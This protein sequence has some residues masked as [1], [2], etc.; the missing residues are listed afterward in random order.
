[1]TIPTGNTLTVNED[2]DLESDDHGTASLINNGTLTA[3]TITAQRYM[4]ANKWHIISP[5]AA[6]QT[7]AAFL[8]ANNNIPTSS[9]NRGMMDYFTDEN[10]W[11]SYYPNTGATGTMDAG[12]GYSAR[13]TSADGVVTFS[14]TLTSGTKEVTLSKVGP[15]DWNC[16]GN[17]YP[18][19]IGMN[20]IAGTTENFVTKNFG[21]LDASYACVYVWD[22]D[23]SYSGQSCYKIISNSEFTLPG[24]TNLSQNYVAPGQGFFVKARNP[25]T[26]ITFTA[27]MQSHQ[28]TKALKSAEK[29]WPGFQLTATTA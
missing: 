5:I 21:S 1:M 17:P 13:I 8:T 29:S 23:P 19:A 15:G 26:D 24:K 11:N 16:I 10:R 6:T 27:A 2:L 20:T 14:G 3:S 28:P 22:E 7:V 25:G 9:S 12:K 18:S 4:T